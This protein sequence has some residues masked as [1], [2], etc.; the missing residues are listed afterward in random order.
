MITSFVDMEAKPIPQQQNPNILA[1]VRL[2]L[3]FLKT[4]FTEEKKSKVK[5]EM[6]DSP[7]MNPLFL[8][9]FMYITLLNMRIPYSNEDKIRGKISQISI[10]EWEK[11]LLEFLND[12]PREQGFPWTEDEKKV[13]ILILYFISYQERTRKHPYLQIKSKDFCHIYD[14]Q[15]FSLGLRP[16]KETRPINVVISFLK[17]VFTEEKKSEV[18]IVLEDKKSPKTN[19]DFLLYFMYISVL[20]KNLARSKKE[21]VFE[22]LS[23]IFLYGETTIEDWETILITF[24]N[25][26]PR[27]EDLPWTEEEKDVWKL[28]LFFV[29]EQFGKHYPTRYHFMLKNQ[30]HRAQLSPLI[31]KLGLKPF[32]K[33]A[34][35]R[36][37]NPFAKKYQTVICRICDFHGDPENPSQTCSC[38]Y[39]CFLK[40]AE[41]RRCRICGQHDSTKCTCC[42]ICKT[43]AEGCLKCPDCNKHECSC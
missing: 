20:D 31:L 19:P 10:E 14:S 33:T 16:F 5:S 21:S 1:I 6:K 28:V 23:N 37:E 11:I 40:D 38:C 7:T 22:K 4:V 30:K 42:R 39:E 41:C 32:K 13:W 12:T 24:L 15:L 2:I 9:Y 17:T 29:S 25:A 34:T 18:K 35:S 27:E 26:T 43:C 8:L 36:P 3:L